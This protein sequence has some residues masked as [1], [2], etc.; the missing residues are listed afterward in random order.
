MY[1]SCSRCSPGHKTRFNLRKAADIQ[2]I[3]KATRGFYVSPTRAPSTA[4]P[5]T[6]GGLFPSVS[7]KVVSNGPYPIARQWQVR[8]TPD[9]CRVAPNTQNRKNFGCRHAARHCVDGRV[10]HHEARVDDEHRRFRN[11]ASL[12]CIQQV[13]FSND[14]AFPVTQ[15]G[16]WQGELRAQSF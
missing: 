6:K 2:D 15:D 1:P 5:A 4:A 9:L 10:S 14:V 3:G 8:L 16:K 12:S 11:A 13:P 7:S